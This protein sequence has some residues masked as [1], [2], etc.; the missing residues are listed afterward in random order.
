[1]VQSLNVELLKTLASEIRLDIVELLLSRPDGLRFS[2]IAKAL[3]I[4][5]STLEDHL[6][7]LTDSNLLIHSENRYI[8]NINTEVA[9]R[10]AQ[11]LAPVRDEPYFAT[12]KLTIKNSEL[13]DR[14]HLLR[15]EIYRDLLSILTKAKNTFSEGIQMGFL[16]G[17]M[18]MHLEQGFFELWNPSF[19]HASMEAVF[20]QE[21][22]KDLKNLNHPELFIE[23]IDPSKIKIYLVD[24]CDYALSGCE[25]GGFLFLPQHDSKVDFSSC[26]CFEDPVGT[27]WL[28]DVFES[29]KAQ[30]IEIGIEE[31]LN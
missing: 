21:G 4:Y 17:T 29:L 13:K 8:A 11:S 31:L 30:S 25:R 28:R 9:S 3:K 16:G 6:S 24:N 27:K 2:D 22:V 7:R 23:A 10:L 1:M 14:F 20:T 26:L 15:F 18:D 5:P 19:K 12:H